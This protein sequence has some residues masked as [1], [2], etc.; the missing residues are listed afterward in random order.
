MLFVKILHHTGHVS[1][2]ARYTKVRG[3]NIT[4]NQIQICESQAFYIYICTHI[5]ISFSRYIKHIHPSL[6]T[7]TNNTDQNQLSFQIC[8]SMEACEI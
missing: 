3:I 4:Q 5:S 6:S 1:E 7:Q 8:I 2:S